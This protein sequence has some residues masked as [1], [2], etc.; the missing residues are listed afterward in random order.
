MAKFVT[1]ASFSEVPKAE[2][3][4][5]ILAEGGVKSYL[6]DSELV[7]MDWLIANAIGGVKVQVAIEDAERALQV[8]AEAKEMQSNLVGD[9]ISDEELTRQ[10][11]AEAPEGEFD[12]EGDPEEMPPPS[13]P[14]RFRK[15]TDASARE[16]TEPVT[17]PKP[18]EVAPAEETNEIS[19]RD[20]NA[21]RAFII[22]WFGLAIPPLAV[23]ALY[24]FV[25]SA[26]G[27]GTLTPRGRYNL[28]VAAILVIPSAIIASMFTSAFIQ[29]IEHP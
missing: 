28:I 4:R 19:E 12:E 10:A 8:L 14:S 20:R 29:I 25:S 13:A 5:N 6:S 7:A 15:F 11:M 3:A 2:I 26:F 27:S 24:F 21:K 17:A 18:P 1:I 23:L 9:N 16:S 22:G